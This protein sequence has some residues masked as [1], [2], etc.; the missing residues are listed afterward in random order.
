MRV[1]RGD[2]I[3]Y[4]CERMGSLYPADETRRIARMVAAALSGEGEAKFLADPAQTIDVEGVETAAR[5]LAAGRPVQYVLGHTE[6]C[7]LRIA[8]RE[9]VLIPRPE[10]EELVMWAGQ[11]AAR[12]AT[13]RILDICTGSGCIAAA[14]AR[15]VAGARV[16][17]VDISDEALDVARENVCSAGVQVEIIKDDAL[18]GMPSLDGRQ[19]DVIVSN[20][21]YIPR[22]EMAAMHRNVTQYEPHMALFVDDGDPLLFYRAIARAARRMLADEGALLFEVHEHLAE[23]TAD[24]L[25]REGFAS[26]EIR[27]DLYGKPRMTCSI[28]NRI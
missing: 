26:T 3:R 18:E 2:I 19:F 14:L 8:V 9:G 6:F 7:G 25:R 10:T 22:A 24:L 23:Q 13:P 27:R 15:R 12:F 11:Q 21:P 16:T 5:Q 20:P 4:L 17:A 28:K 1:S